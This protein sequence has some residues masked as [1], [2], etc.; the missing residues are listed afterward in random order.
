MVVTNE[1]IEAAKQKGRDLSGGMPGAFQEACAEIALAGLTA[2][3]AVAPGVDVKPLEWTR[4][5]EAVGFD[6]RYTVYE[7]MDGWNCVKYPH[8]DSHYRLSESVTEEAA[9]SAAQA[10]YT[11]RIMSAI[12]TTECDPE[13]GEHQE[14]L[15]AIQSHN[16]GEEE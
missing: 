12:A 13:P 8:G 9:K 6:C 11:A 16:S 14:V 10:D 3:L 4:H 15:D 5:G 2:A 1:M 7:A